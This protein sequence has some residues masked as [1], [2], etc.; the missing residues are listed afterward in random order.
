MQKA[1][2]QKIYGLKIRNGATF[3]KIQQPPN[4]CIEI[5]L[6]I[7]DLDL[8]TFSH[9]Q[10]IQITK[11]S[12]NFLASSPSKFV[13]KAVVSLFARSWFLLQLLFTGLFNTAFDNTHMACWTSYAS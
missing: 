2:F 12:C 10:E 4:S 5:W 7:Y 13:K 11:I 9:F 1:G 6:I 8:K 3:L